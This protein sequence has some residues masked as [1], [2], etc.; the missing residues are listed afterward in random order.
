VGLDNWSGNA[1]GNRWQGYSHQ[2]LYD[3]LHSGPGPAAAGVAADR[4]S[5]MAGALSDIQQDI[6]SGVAASGA[7][8]VGT[9][10][11]SA[12][13]ALNPLGQWAEQASSAADVMR[14][15]AELQGD[16]LSK[17]RADMP[18]PIAIPQQTSQIS[19]LVTAQV[20]Y[21]MT[22]AA[23]QVAAQQAFQVMAQYEAG[24][25]DNTDTLGDFGEPP[26]LHVDTTPIT[27]VA[28][29]GRIRVTQPPRRLPRPAP[30]AGRAAPAPIEE[31]T[32][33]AGSTSTKAPTTA[34]PAPPVA[35]V[36]ET[37]SPTPTPTA[38]TGGA[39][40]AT[41]PTAPGTTS[42]AAPTSTSSSPSSAESGPTT[43]PSAAEATAPSSATPT[44]NLTGI[45]PTRTTGA[46]RDKN[47]A[48]GPVA[49]PRIGGIVPSARRPNAND[50]EDEE[51]ESKYLIEAE[52]IY[53][54]RRSYTPPVIGES[55]SHR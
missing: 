43:A 51:H 24:T 23:S 28:V 9:A 49:T 8:W 25:T 35:P 54:D 47:A 16:L 18:A 15:S 19:Q 1:S 20:D 10:A 29:R 48:A 41:E 6:S 42:S 12:H 45:P 39:P 46:T 26:T 7:A 40:A 4:W 3:M 31:P 32:G 17:A 52:D 5:S 37:E 27:G 38:P 33:T 13:G 44:E 30:T 2:Q 34:E 50:D 53:G 11:D 21:E 22:E 36:E 55:R 14:I